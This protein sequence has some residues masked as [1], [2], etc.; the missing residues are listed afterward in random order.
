VTSRIIINRLVYNTN[1]NYKQTHELFGLW[2]RQDVLKKLSANAEQK[3]VTADRLT[4]DMKY[5]PNILDILYDFEQPH[6]ISLLK[7]NSQNWLVSHHHPD[8]KNHWINYRYGTLVATD[9]FVHLVQE[10]AD[11]DTESMTA[12]YESISRSAIEGSSPRRRMNIYFGDKSRHWRLVEAKTAPDEM[13]NQTNKFINKKARE[14]S[15]F[16]NE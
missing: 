2:T 13:L 15:Y 7:S 11:Y 5:Y 4:G 3:Y 1:N 9:Y 8:F 16:L 6:Y 14:R 10:N 12:S